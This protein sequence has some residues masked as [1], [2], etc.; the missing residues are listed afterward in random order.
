M[1]APRDDLPFDW[2]ALATAPGLHAGHLRAAAEAGLAPAQLLGQKEATLRA[3]GLTPGGARALVAPDER[4]LATVRDWA[5]RVSATLLCYGTARYPPRL[6]ATPDAPVA[7]WVLGDATALLRPQVAVVGSRRP[8]PAGRRDARAFAADLAR[9]GLVVTSGLALG[10]DAEGHAGALD[11]GGLSIAVCGTGLD[12]CYPPRHA[13]LARRLAASGALVSEF[14][15]GVL[16]RAEHFPRRNRIISGLAL[17]VVVVEAARDSG[18]LITARLALDQ[19]RSVMAVPGSIHSAVSRGCHQLL[20]QGAGLVENAADILA[21]L[22]WGP[23]LP[24]LNQELV[25]DT[26]GRVGARW[27]DKAGE[28]LLDALGFEPVSIEDLIVRTGQ[29][30]RDVASMLV[31]LELEGLVETLPGGLYGRTSHPACRKAN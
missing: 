1:Q 2:L 7:L 20:R 30:A 18:S 16:P 26:E 13:A 23:P 22:N 11:A 10:I 17:G 29:P 5:A 27:L 14:P 8:T 9:A 19:G 4:A 24:L 25:P 21:E 6:A 28:M 12:T 15:P 31:L 3:L